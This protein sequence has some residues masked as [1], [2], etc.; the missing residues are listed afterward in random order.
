MSL[1]PPSLPHHETLGECVHSYDCYP[2]RRDGPSAPRTTEQDASVRRRRLRR[3]WSSCAAVYESRRSATLCSDVH[4]GPPRRMH[5]VRCRADKELQC[6]ER[7][8]GRRRSRS[9]T[10]GGCCLAL[11]TRPTTARRCST[12]CCRWLGRTP[13][14]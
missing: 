3:F 13:A 12:P 5:T 10:N 9:C 1:H 14:P 11:G 6:R 7:G 2:R 4:G 8:C